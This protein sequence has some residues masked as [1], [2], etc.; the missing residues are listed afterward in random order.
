MWSTDKDKFDKITEREYKNFICGFRSDTFFRK[1]SYERIEIIVVYNYSSWYSE[2]MYRVSIK[3]S[4]KDSINFTSTCY[5]NNILD[6]IKSIS[7]RVED[8]L[9]DYN[10]K[11]DN[12]ESDLLS[13]LCNN[14][15]LR[16]FNKGE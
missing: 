13:I 11:I 9:I 10:V 2:Y 12:I 14:E 6:L 1:D 8:M 3:S 16:L 5:E 7:N 15:I 4:V